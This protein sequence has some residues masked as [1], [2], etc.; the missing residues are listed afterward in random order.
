MNGY[1]LDTDTWIEFF[2]HRGSVADHIAKCLAS[3]ALIGSTLAIQ[4]NNL[5]C[6]S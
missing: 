5:V 4:A 6:Y 1:I 2:H 3:T